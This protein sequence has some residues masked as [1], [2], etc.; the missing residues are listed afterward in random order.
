MIREHAVLK[1]H[2]GLIQV[3]CLNGAF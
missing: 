1:T 2:K 3:T